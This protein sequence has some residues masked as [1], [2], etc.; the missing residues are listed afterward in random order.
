MSWVSV[1][2]MVI[3]PP[4]SLIVVEKAYLSLMPSNEATHSSHRCSVL[5]IIH[6]HASYIDTMNYDQLKYFFN[7]YDLLS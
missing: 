1:I 2:D 6:T 3:F 4:K 7:L 5:F